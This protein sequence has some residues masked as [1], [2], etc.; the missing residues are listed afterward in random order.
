[1]QANGKFFLAGLNGA[2]YN[3]GISL[4]SQLGKR[5]GSLQVSFQNVNRTPSFVF[6]P[7]SSYL[8]S[9]DSS[10]N[11]ENWIVLGGNLYLNRINLRLLGQ[12]YIVSNYTYWDNYYHARQQGTLQNVLHL[13]AEKT[14][15]YYQAL[16]NGYAEVHFQTRQLES[17]ITCPCLYHGIVL[18]TREN[19]IKT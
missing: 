13:G 7:R 14:H 19:F 9:G 10:L 6:D 18:Y 1:V 12:Y 5:F 3:A 17:D 4:E 2:D 16:G 15:K 8:F 11:K